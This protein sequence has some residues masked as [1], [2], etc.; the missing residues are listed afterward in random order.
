MT[1]LRHLGG[2]SKLGALDSKNGVKKMA[3]SKALLP[4]CLIV[5]PNLILAHAI[6]FLCEE[7]MCFISFVPILECPW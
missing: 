2:Q 6:Y 4:H 3:M 5:L 7:F 1:E